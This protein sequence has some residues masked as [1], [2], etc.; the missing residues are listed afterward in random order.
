MLET[1]IYLNG[2]L[3]S[4]VTIITYAYNHALISKERKLRKLIKE[5]QQVH[6]TLVQANTDTQTRLNEM[7]L[8][9]AAWS[10]KL[11]ARR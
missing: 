1:L 2:I 8:E 10:D 7:G 6:N 11:R 3:I 4:A 5:I 9:L